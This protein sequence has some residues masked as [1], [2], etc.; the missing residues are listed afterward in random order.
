MVNIAGS[1]QQCVLSRL[2]FISIYRASALYCIFPNMS[3]ES[4]EVIE[5]HCGVDGF[6]C[7]E[8]TFCARNKVC[9]GCGCQGGC[10]EWCVFVGGDGPSRT[11][12][13]LESE[14]EDLRKSVRCLENLLAGLE[15]QLVFFQEEV[16][17]LTMAGIGQ[18]SR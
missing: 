15:P 10:K 12:E 2:L 13:R 1:G 9:K 18:D 6:D 11:I 16:K 14:N 8:C 4:E 7:G 17:R 5:K 3:L